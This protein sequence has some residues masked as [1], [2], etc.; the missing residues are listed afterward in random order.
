MGTARW[1]RTLFGRTSG[2][3]HWYRCRLQ[4]VR[5]SDRITRMGI[6]ILCAGRIDGR[7]HHLVLFYHVRYARKAS[8]NRRSG[9]Q[10]HRRKFDGNIGWTNGIFL[11][12]NLSRKVLFFQ[13]IPTGMA[14]D[15]E[16]VEIVTVLGASDALVR[17]QLGHFLLAYGCP[18]IFEWGIA[19][20]KKYK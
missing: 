1:E 10:I 18:A 7:L 9:T 2:L 3:W 11:T 17:T 8:E 4:F 5:H 19:N 16:Y 6:C 20:N 14:T 13:N 15:L 12:V